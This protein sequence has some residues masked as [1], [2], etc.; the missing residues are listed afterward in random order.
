MTTIQDF[1]PYAIGAFKVGEAIVVLDETS[2]GYCG[3]VF[4]DPT[5]NPSDRAIWHFDNLHGPACGVHDERSLAV[6]ACSL[7]GYYS[8]HNRGADL[9]DWAPEPEIAD[10]IES[11]AC[12]VENSDEVEEIEEL[13]EWI[14]AYLSSDEREKNLRIR[15][16][17]LAAVAESAWSAA[18]ENW[19]V[20]PAAWAAW[21]VAK[22]AY[23]AWVD[24]KA[25]KAETTRRP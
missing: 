7:G 11:A 18:L 14:A 1:M 13:P 9:P 22:S 4:A 8:T 5:I 15:A 24:A 3:I 20:W 6:S 25:A 23:R 10:A 21:S 12:C 17:E 16:E 19:A 2:S